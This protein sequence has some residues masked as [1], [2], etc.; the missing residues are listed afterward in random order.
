M[1]MLIHKSLCG[2]WKTK[3]CTDLW[4]EVPCSLVQVLPRH[5]HIC[6]K[7][8]NDITQKASNLHSHCCEN[9]KL[10]IPTCLNKIGNCHKKIYASY[11]AGCPT[12]SSNWQLQ[13]ST[14]QPQVM[15]KGGGRTQRDDMIMTRV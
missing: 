6:I 5:Q 14:S 4:D 1:E 11:S 3:I 7:Q 8:H 15:R 12:P 2:I 13:Y 9:L 10:K